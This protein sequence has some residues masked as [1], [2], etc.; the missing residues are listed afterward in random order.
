MGVLT[1]K[2]TEY[3]KDKSDQSVDN[4]FKISQWNQKRSQS[5]NI[6]NCKHFSASL[7]YWSLKNASWKLCLIFLYEQIYDWKFMKL[8]YWSLF[9]SFYR[10]LE[11]SRWGDVQK[12]SSLESVGIRNLK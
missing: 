10:K 3:D 4:S 1:N 7:D 8:I 5:T 2:S 12:Y 6:T 11:G 9:Y